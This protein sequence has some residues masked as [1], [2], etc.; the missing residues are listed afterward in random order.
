MVE[1]IRLMRWTDEASEEAI[2][3]SSEMEKK[4]D[5]D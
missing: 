5:D 3:S 1:H 2:D 4:E